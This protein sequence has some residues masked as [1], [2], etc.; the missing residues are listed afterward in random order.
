[1]SEHRT[2]ETLLVEPG[3]VFGFRTQP[4]FAD[5]P[6]ETGRY[7]AFVVL[8]HNAEMIALGVLDGVWTSMPTLEQVRDRELLRR[9]RFFFRGDVAAF[10]CARDDVPALAELSAL[11]RLP[12]SAAQERIAAKYLDEENR[13]G[14]SF[15]SAVGVN[16]DV[17][18]EWRWA[19]DREALQHEYEL[20]EQRREQE[21]AA[22]QER[23]ETRLKGLTW[24]QLLSEHPFERWV[25]SPPFPPAEFRDAATARVHDTYRALQSL[26]A[27]P[28]KPA[29]RK[30]LKDLVLWF[31][32]A[33]DEAGGVIETEEREDI[34]LVLEEIAH[35]ARHPALLQEAD[36]WRDW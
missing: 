19:H 10:S 2:R 29:A 1:M 24:Q 26:G 15:G 4:I 32:H 12:L 34:F 25:P 5:S 23:Y 7:G 16:S 17:E 20:T 22:A 30:I 27:K 18:G 3:T 28:R 9:N 33:D 31:N 36:S 21:R 6:P 8:A 11:G 14:T 35:V 13:I